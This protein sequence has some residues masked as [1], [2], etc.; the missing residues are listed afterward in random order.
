MKSSWV[1][2]PKVTPT[3]VTI[4]QP[5]GVQVRGDKSN[6]KKMIVHKKSIMPEGLLAS[7]KPQDVADLLEFVVTAP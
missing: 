7:L 2:S 6:I 5:H 1:P 3:S 4:T